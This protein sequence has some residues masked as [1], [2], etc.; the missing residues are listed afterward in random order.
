MTDDDR[1]CI[2]LQV[3][4]ALERLDELIQREDANRLASDAWALLHLDP[5]RQRLQSASDLLVRSWDENQTG[6]AQIAH[7]HVDR[8]IAIYDGRP[9]Q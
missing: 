8:A 6:A 5:T 3:R 7:C 9:V 2:A 4:Y 1:E